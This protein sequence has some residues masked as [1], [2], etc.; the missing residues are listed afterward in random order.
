MRNL[1]EDGVR[2]TQAELEKEFLTLKKAVIEI[3]DAI[4]CMPI[5]RYESRRL[6]EAV[7]ALKPVVEVEFVDASDDGKTGRFSRLE[8]D[9]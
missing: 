4:Q 8:P 5:G 3:V 6:N 2:V 9:A 1:R 7:R